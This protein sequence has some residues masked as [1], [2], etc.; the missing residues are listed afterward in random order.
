VER[1]IIVDD[2]GRQ[3]TSIFELLALEGNPLLIKR[4]SFLVCVMRLDVVDGVVRLDV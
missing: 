2:V 1:G 3:S 4:N